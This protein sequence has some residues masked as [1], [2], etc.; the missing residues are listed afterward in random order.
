MAAPAAEDFAVEPSD[1]LTLFF[2]EDTP[3]YKYVVSRKAFRRYSGWVN[4][5]LAGDR[6]LPAV[7]LP[8]ALRYPPRDSLDETI[9]RARTTYPASA[10]VPAPV[11]PVAAAGAGAG[12]GTEEEEEEY[13]YEVPPNP[14]AMFDRTNAMTQEEAN[15]IP[16][17]GLDVLMKAVRVCLCGAIGMAQCCARA[18]RPFVLCICTTCTRAGIARRTSSSASTVRCT[19]TASRA[20][21]SGRRISSTSSGLRRTWRCWRT[22]AASCRLRCKRVACI[23][24]RESVL[25]TCVVCARRLFQLPN[26]RWAL[27]V[28]HRHCIGKPEPTPEQKAWGEAFQKDHPELFPA[29]DMVTD[30]VYDEDG[31]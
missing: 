16:A 23:Y 8:L 31:E 4:S 9:K 13:D 22:L 19:T 18:C 5:S 2:P 30:I 29:P 3:E 21:P 7:S 15:A 20:C 24:T 27:I 12:A 11:V 28:K 1:A 14:Y 26:A 6:D 10:P 25:R 17:Q